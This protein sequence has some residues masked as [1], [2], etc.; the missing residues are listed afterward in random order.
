[1]YPNLFSPVE[2]TLLY[3]GDICNIA[4]LL[5]SERGT[6][7]L[8]FSCCTKFVPSFSTTSVAQLQPVPSPKA[9]WSHFLPAMWR[10]ADALGRKSEMVQHFHFRNSA[11]L[12]VQFQLQ[13]VYIWSISFKASTLVHGLTKFG[14]IVKN[15]RKLG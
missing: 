7:S 15:C 8:Y 13:T 3:P 10:L 2:F 1:M 11:I 4:T 6:L 14:K 12:L 5:L 9:V